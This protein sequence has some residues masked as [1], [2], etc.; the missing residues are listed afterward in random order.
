MAFFLTSLKEFLT[1]QSTV[2]I[3]KKTFLNQKLTDQSEYCNMQMQNKQLFIQHLIKCWSFDVV[4]ED[5]T[6]AWIYATFKE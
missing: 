4:T 1:N 2:I 5:S 6:R 3:E